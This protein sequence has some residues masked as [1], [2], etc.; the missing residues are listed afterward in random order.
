[1]KDPKY[2]LIDG[3]LRTSLIEPVTIFADACFPPLVEPVPRLI[4]AA[5]VRR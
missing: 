5:P 3:A 2:L 1:M 4:L